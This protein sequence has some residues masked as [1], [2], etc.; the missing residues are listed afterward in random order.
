MDA[1]LSQLPD[2]L[3]QW[4]RHCARD[5]PWRHTKDPDRIWVS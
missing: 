5:L 1:I 2:T 3:P 4:D